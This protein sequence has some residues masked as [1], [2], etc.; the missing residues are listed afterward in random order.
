MECSALTIWLRGDSD[1]VVRRDRCMSEEMDQLEEQS[2]YLAITQQAEEA[3]PDHY[4]P[5][6][7]PGE[8]RTRPKIQRTVG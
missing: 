6:A 4:P 2:R 7:T 3:S 8:C 1:P 5:P